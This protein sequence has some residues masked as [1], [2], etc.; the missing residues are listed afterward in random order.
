MQRPRGRNEQRV[1]KGPEGRLWWQSLVDEGKR[2]D[3]KGKEPGRSQTGEGRGSL[4]G[5]GGRV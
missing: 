5:L 4:A 3:N 1:I 2:V